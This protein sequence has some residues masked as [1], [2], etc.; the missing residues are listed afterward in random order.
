MCQILYACYKDIEQWPIDLVQLFIEDSLLVES[1]KMWCESSHPI[2]S[3]FV[4]N[5]LTG[6]GDRAVTTTEW[7]RNR[8]VDESLR[9]KIKTQIVKLIQQPP[10]HEVLFSVPTSFG[11]SSSNNNNSNNNNNNIATPNSENNLNVSTGNNMLLQIGSAAMKQYWRVLVVGMKY[12]QVRITVVSIVEDWLN[13]VLHPTH[14]PKVA[15]ELLFQLL[16][17]IALHYADQIEEQ[18]V[19]IALLRLKAKPAHAP[20]YMDML[21][22]ILKFVPKFA[23]L[24]LRHLIQTELLASPKMTPSISGATTSHTFIQNPQYAPKI[25][26]AIYKA[27]GESKILL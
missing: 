21:H 23:P 19:F 17:C 3:V 4:N 12:R 22:Y 18:P 15:R 16:Q 26:F 5:L 8:Y 9:E 27:L 24:A 2:V 13:S 7:I 11:P 14:A 25:L 6:F 20:L 1:T 10:S